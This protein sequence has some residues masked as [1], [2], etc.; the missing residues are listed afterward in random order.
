MGNLIDRMR[1]FAAGVFSI[2]SIDVVFK[3]AGLDMQKKLPIHFRQNL[4]LIFKEAINNIAKHAEASRVAIHLENANGAFKMT[5]QDDGKILG[6]L[7]RSTG[8]GLRNMRMRAARI[9]GDL[10]IR[11]NGGCTVNLTAPAL[12]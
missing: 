11:R 5:I 10:E 12:R 6:E 9:G 3:L 7:E 2:Q 4:Y 8:H 1:D